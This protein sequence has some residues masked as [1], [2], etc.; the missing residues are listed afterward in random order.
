MPTS[1]THAVNFDAINESINAGSASALDNMTAF[2][3]GMLY[4]ATGAGSLGRLISKR[5]ASAGWSLNASNTSGRLDVSWD[6]ATTDGFA[7]FGG[8]VILTNDWSWLFV[9]FD[10][11]NGTNLFS[12]RL[13]AY[14]GALSSI[15]GAGV[16][17][18]SGAFTDDATADVRIGADTLVSNSVRPMDVAFV[19]L[20]PSVLS[21]ATIDSYAADMSGNGGLTAATDYFKFD[22]TMTSSATSGKGI[23]TGTYTGITL[24]DGPDP[25]PTG[26]GFRTYYL[27]G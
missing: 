7:L 3:V 21:T 26:P 24:G 15:T 17:V 25:A 9:T 14:G 12:C 20:W 2:T 27:N 19:G 22:G 1:Y 8:A 23:F 13:G 11:S 5:N 10:Q 16:T 18:G 6:R 4:R